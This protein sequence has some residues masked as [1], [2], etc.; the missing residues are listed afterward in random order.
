MTAWPGPVLASLAV[1]LSGC[2]AA[3]IQPS[4]K[5]EWTIPS[6]DPLAADGEWVEQGLGAATLRVQGD[7]VEIHG[8]CEVFRGRRTGPARLQQIEGGS[9]SH[10]DAVVHPIVDATIEPKG[11]PP[12]CRSGPIEI[13]ELEAHVLGLRI[14]GR[15]MVQVVLDE[16]STRSTRPEG[17]DLS[18]RGLTVLLPG[19]AE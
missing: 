18:W 5:V 15:P 16:G 13:G 14:D 12:S 19:G 2:F 7:H 6:W 11:S 1:G 9:G 8:S 10:H 3:P 4:P 17:A